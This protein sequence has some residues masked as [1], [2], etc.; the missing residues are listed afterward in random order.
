MFVIRPL[1]EC[2]HCRV[3]SQRSFCL[4]LSRLSYPSAFQPSEQF[5][6]NKQKH[7]THCPLLRFVES[8]PTLRTLSCRWLI[9]VQHSLRF[10]LYWFGNYH[11]ASAQDSKSAP[12]L[13]RCL[14]MYSCFIFNRRIFFAVHQW[15]LDLPFFVE[16]LFHIF[17]HISLF[18]LYDVHENVVFI[19]ENQR[20]NNIFCG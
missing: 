2:S 15:L 16:Y 18:S 9:I 1:M 12:T 4:I 19:L 14:T 3:S 5:L 10:V 7:Y 20:F 13:I 8:S 11:R 17:L 6:T